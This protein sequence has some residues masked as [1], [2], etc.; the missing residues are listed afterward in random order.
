METRRRKVRGKEVSIGKKTGNRRTGLKGKWE[1]NGLLNK[2]K[3]KGGRRE[4]RN[5]NK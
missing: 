1:D 3:G 4:D 2:R 5:D